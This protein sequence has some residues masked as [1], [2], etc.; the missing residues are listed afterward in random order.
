MKS[1]SKIA[2]ATVAVALLTASFSHASEKDKTVLVNVNQGQYS[3]T[4]VCEKQSPTIALS[5][6]NRSIR[7]DER[8]S[9]V[10]PALVPQTIRVGQGSTVTYFR[11]ER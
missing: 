9:A 4:Y 11:A 2:A 3:V 7:S 1:Q 8:S 10:A 6:N 5:V